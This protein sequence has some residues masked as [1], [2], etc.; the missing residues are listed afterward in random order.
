MA[1]GGSRVAE[2]GGVV[3]FRIVKWRLQDARGEVDIVH[4]GVVIGVDGGRRHAPF[5]A[6]DRLAD[7][8]ELALRF[9]DMR[10]FDVAE[11]VVAA[12][13]DRAVI[14]PMVG[15][16][17]FISDAVQFFERAL[18]GTGAHPWQLLNFR[19]HGGFDV[20]GHLQGAALGGGV[21]GFC[22]KH[23]AKGFA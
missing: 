20:T 11:I 15:V 17:D 8:A 19:L 4:L 16:S 2:V 9:E 3:H 7:F 14:A 1:D 22:D 12:N 21:E 5:A 10:A 13:F 23:L 6:I 18:F